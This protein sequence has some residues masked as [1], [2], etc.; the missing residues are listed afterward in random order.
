MQFKCSARI[1]KI[2]VMEKKKINVHEGNLLRATYYFNR[3]SFYHISVSY[4]RTFINIVRFIKCE[5]K[6]NI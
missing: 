4:I 5:T 2:V 1:G 3:Y 6:T